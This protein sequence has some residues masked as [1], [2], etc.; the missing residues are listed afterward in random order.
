MNAERF[1]IEG[2]RVLAVED[3][4]TLTHGEMTYGAAVL[5]AKQGGAAALVDPR[6]FA[7]G[8][9]CNWKRVSPGESVRTVT[10]VSTAGAASASAACDDSRSR[11]VRNANRCRILNNRVKWH[12]PAEI[13]G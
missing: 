13:K 8:S 12:D 6:P 9:M 3:G 5:A 10:F 7:V 4:P 11:A 2:K 1:E